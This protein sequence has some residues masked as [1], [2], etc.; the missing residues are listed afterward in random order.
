MREYLENYQEIKNYIIIDDNP[1]FMKNLN[2]DIHF[3]LTDNYLT[4]KNYYNILDT[5]QKF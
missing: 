3:V 2:D 1:Y 5:K 4:K